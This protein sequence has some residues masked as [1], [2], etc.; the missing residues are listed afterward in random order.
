M[1][2]TFGAKRGHYIDGES[3]E[4]GLDEVFGDF[5]KDG[6]TYLVEDFEAFS[7]IEVSIV[8]NEGQKDEL[9]VETEADMGRADRAVPAKKALNRFLKIVTGYSPEGRKEKMK[10]DV[11]KS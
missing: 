11:E 8:Q 6:D 1:G 9:Q 10:R 3:V 4:R 5:S 2:R 7:R